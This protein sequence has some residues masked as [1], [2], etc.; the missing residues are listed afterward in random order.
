MQIGDRVTVRVNTYP[1]QRYGLLIGEVTNV[2][3][4]NAAEGNAPSGI[5]TVKIIDFSSFTLDPEISLRNG[6]TVDSS[7]KVG[8]ELFFPTSPIRLQMDYVS[9]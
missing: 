2:A 4:G 3:L 6:L 9:L 5:L 7:V 1:Y 8:Q